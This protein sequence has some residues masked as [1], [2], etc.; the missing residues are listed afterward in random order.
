MYCCV[1]LSLTIQNVPGLIVETLSQGISGDGDDNEDMTIW[2]Y[3]N[4]LSLLQLGHSLLP[5]AHT[6][7]DNLPKAHTQIECPLA[8]G[9]LQR[10][11]VYKA[12]F[13]LYINLAPPNIK[14]ALVAESQLA[15]KCIQ[16]HVYQ[17]LMLSRC[18]DPN[19][20]K[21]ITSDDYLM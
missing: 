19:N 11:R 20:R 6:L 17:E 13:C 12:F 10:S 5:R 18:S 14:V 7:A 2:W 16:P 3:S 1:R 9:Y 21:C 15:G 4:S 8:A